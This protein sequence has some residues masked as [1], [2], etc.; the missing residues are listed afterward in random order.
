MASLV[1]LSVALLVLIDVCSSDDCTPDDVNLD[2]CSVWDDMSGYT[3]GTC[4]EGLKRGPIA[5]NKLIETCRVYAK[6]DIVFLIDRSESIR[7]SQYQCAVDFIQKLITY[8][9]TE[10]LLVVGEEHSHVAIVSYGIASIVTYDGISSEASAGSLTS[11]NL[12]EKFQT[13][14][15]SDSGSQL[16]A[17]LQ[18]AIAILSSS[19]NKEATKKVLIVV[20]DGEETGETNIFVNQ[21]DALSR[22]NVATFAIG[23][24]HGWMNEM[25]EAALLQLVTD[26]EHFACRFHWNA[27]L[28]E[29]KGNNTQTGLLLGSNVYPPVYCI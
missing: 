24:D 20:S 8:L 29:K 14:V 2:I 13:S 19:L 22:L 3:N 11:C 21:T 27:A 28:Q 12:G 25:R 15:K 17:A 9:S 18:R 5:L 4:A 7:C 10:S 6:L 26:E 16:S 23:Q 1:F